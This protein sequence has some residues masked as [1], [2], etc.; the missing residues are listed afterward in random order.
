LFIGLGFFGQ[1]VGMVSLYELFQAKRDQDAYGHHR[2]VHQEF[3]E[4]E[5][6][7]VGSMNFHT[8]MLA[9]NIRNLNSTGRLSE[10]QV[11]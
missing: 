11:L 5:D 8:G 6:G 2:Q 9:K 10:D 3:P 4:R 1:F 7:L